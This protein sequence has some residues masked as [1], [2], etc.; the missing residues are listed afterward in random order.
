[1]EAAFLGPTLFMGKL[2]RHSA[3]PAA[4]VPQE[5]IGTSVAVVVGDAHRRLHSGVSLGAV[6]VQLCLHRTRLDQGDESVKK[7]ILS[8]VKG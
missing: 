2:G 7:R 3:K 6:K 4:A 8:L 1:M 5:Q